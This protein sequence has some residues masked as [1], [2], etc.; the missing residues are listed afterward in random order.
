MR[1]NQAVQVNANKGTQQ[2]FAANGSSVTI[3]SAIAAINFPCTAVVQLPSSFSQATAYYVLIP[4]TIF[5]S[6]A[7]PYFP[8]FNDPGNWSFITSGVSTLSVI[9]LSPPNGAFNA[10]IGGFN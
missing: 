6:Y 9:N 1:A 5:Q 8:G 10:T 7:L 4:G 2:L 3:T